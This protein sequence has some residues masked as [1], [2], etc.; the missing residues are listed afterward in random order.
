[1]KFVRFSFEIPLQRL[2]WRS[3]G[4]RVYNADPKKDK[5]CH[6]SV[7]EA[8]DPQYAMSSGLVM[9]TIVQ[10]QGI[11]LSTNEE[12][13]F[14]WFP[15]PDTY[16]EADFQIIHGVPTMITYDGESWTSYLIPLLTHISAHANRP[17]VYPLKN[18]QIDTVLCHTVFMARELDKDLAAQKTEQDLRNL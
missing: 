18:K 13:G 5:H 16:T 15:V 17:G 7:L 3:D 12:D 1:M 4:T 14:V 6:V 8:K 9:D 11:L 10:P 2:L